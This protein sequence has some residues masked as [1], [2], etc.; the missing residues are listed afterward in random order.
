MST[1]APTRRATGIIDAAHATAEDEMEGR[2][3]TMRTTVCQGST[4]E[5]AHTVLAQV[6]ST[7]EE[8]IQWVSV[9]GDEVDALAC[10][11]GV[12]A[13]ADPAPGRAVGLASRDELIQWVS[14]YSDEVAW[15]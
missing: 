15:G 5:G 12:E 11:G 8:L 4:A 10:R 14:L 7:R 6:G 1:Q 3:T 13:T 2:S 9:Y